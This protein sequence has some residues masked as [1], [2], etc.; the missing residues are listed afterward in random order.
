MDQ[1]DASG[2]ATVAKDQ[3]GQVGQTAAQAG[4]QV[5]QTTKEQAQNVV[6]EAKQ[7]ARDLVGEARAQARDQAGTQKGR[8][9]SGLR[10]L[11]GELDDMAQQG[12]QSGIA[13]EV[14]R[15]VAQRAHG[16][17]DHL[18][19]HEPAELLDQVRSY[20]RRRP[21]AFLA[22][23]AVLGVLAGR[24]TRGLTSNDDSGPRQLTGG[25]TTPEYPAGYGTDY[26]AGS[27][28]Q[29]A[30]VYPV[31]T[32]AAPLG[33]PVGGY[34]PGYGAGQP[35]GGFRPAGE[36]GYPAA[37]PG[38]PAGDPGYSAGTGYPA[39]DPGY[40]AG[41]ETGYPGT[42]HQPPAGYEGGA[43]DPAWRNP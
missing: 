1:Q 16:L 15:Q 21:V 2:V 7:Q 10:S 42:S 29:T 37:E 11:A 9:V 24:M 8:A 23:A 31:G 40:P 25:T 6:G 14:A 18:D 35:G 3:A 34:E 43:E 27:G 30:P 32:E 41:T 38:Y 20:A 33:E 28:Y 5:A 12:G 22:G 13:T 17:A 26:P 19:R 36:P 4:G 39:G